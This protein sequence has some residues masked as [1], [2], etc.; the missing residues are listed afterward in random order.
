MPIHKVLAPHRRAIKKVLEA[1]ELSSRDGNIRSKE[2]EEGKRR[3]LKGVTALCWELARIEFGVDRGD[4]ADA[5][6]RSAKSLRRQ[7]YRWKDDNGNVP[8]ARRLAI[9]LAHAKAQQWYSAKLAQVPDVE[10]LHLALECE[11]RIQLD[12]FAVIAEQL[13]ELSRG[14]SELNENDD[15]GQLEVLSWLAEFTPGMIE[16]LSSS[17]RH[18]QK[19]GLPKRSPHQYFIDSRVSGQCKAALSAW[20]NLVERLGQGT[21]RANIFKHRQDEFNDP[22]EDMDGPPSGFYESIDLMDES[23][24]FDDSTPQVLSQ[25]TRKRG[26]PRKTPS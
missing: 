14:F 10:E 1:I 15:S 24:A 20:T 26:R 11:A 7:W 8:G 2:K 5:L 12:R 21:Q 23:S 3:V 4:C 16:A 18:H 19:A 25:P 13:R 17:L 9:I 6:E 22:M